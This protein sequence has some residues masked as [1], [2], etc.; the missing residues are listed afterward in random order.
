MVFLH[1]PQSYEP[2]EYYEFFFIC[3]MGVWRALEGPLWLHHAHAGSHDY[4]AR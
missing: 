2:Y 4:A 3:V 1:L